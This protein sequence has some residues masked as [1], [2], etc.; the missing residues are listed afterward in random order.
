MHYRRDFRYAESEKEHLYHHIGV[1]VFVV[2]MS[3]LPIVGEGPPAQALQACRRVRD[4]P[5]R[6][7]ADQ[8][9][10]PT[11]RHPLQKDHRKFRASLHKTGGQHDIG[12]LAAV[13]LLPQPL[14][15]RRDIAG[16]ML[17]VPVHLDHI[18]VAVVYGVP[19]ADLQGGPIAHPLHIGQHMYRP[20]PDLLGRG[21]A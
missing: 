21:V 6:Y 8:K 11:E 14:K 1:R 12:M 17:A 3:F 19:V 20:L 7:G 15:D 5:L 10:K 13:P 16:V 2:E 4:P 9:A 18:A